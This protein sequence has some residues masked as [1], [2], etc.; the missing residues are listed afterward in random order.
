MC[1][2]G[3]QFCS[4]ITSGVLGKERFC[5]LAFVQGIAMAFCRRDWFMISISFHMACVTIMVP[6]QCLLPCVMAHP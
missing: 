3:E 6:R 2:S 5:I 4:T 1:I